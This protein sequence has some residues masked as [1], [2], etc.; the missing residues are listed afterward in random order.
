MIFAAG[1][2]TRMRELTLDCPK[3]LIEVAG[4]TLIDRALALADQAGIARKVVN[5]HYLGHMIEAHLA[6]RCD[7]AFSPEPDAALETGGGLQKALPLL[8]D[9]PVFTLNPDAIWTGGNPLAALATAWHPGRMAAL[10][11][12]VPKSRATGHA[13]A[14]DFTLGDDGLLQRFTGNGAPLIYGGAQIIATD[15]L[16]DMPKGAFSLNLLWDRM[17]T[18]G[19]L[20]GIVHPGGWADVGTPEGIALAETLLKEVSDV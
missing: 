3:P 15:G 14:G 4:Q 12:L 7:I 1:H 16:A 18:E 2:G 8:G 6:G 20:Y 17:Q 13:G 10:L 9:A 19:R 5:L 11:S